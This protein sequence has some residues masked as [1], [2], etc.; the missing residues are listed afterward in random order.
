MINGTA[1]SLYFL[2][3]MIGGLRRGEGLAFQWHL[4]VDW[5]RGGFYVNRSISKTVNGQPL[6]KAP[7]ISQLKTFC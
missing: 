7:K 2:G 4:D 1:I 3:A 6:V 5:D